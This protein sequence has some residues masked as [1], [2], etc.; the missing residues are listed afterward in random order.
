MENLYFHHYRARIAPKGSQRP[1]KKSLSPSKGSPSVHASATVSTATSAPVDSTHHTDQRQNIRPTDVPKTSTAVTTAGED[2][3]QAMEVDPPADQDGPNPIVV[4]QSTSSVQVTQVTQ[5][6]PNDLASHSINPST[7]QSSAVGYALS[8]TKPP[9]PSIQRSPTHQRRN[10]TAHMPTPQSQSPAPSGAVTPPTPRNK[11]L[12]GKHSLSQPA[13]SSLRSR[14]PTH[15][16]R[17]SNSAPSSLLPGSPT[18]AL[19]YDSFWSS[20]SA[21]TNYRSSLTGTASYPNLHKGGYPFSMGAP[22][23]PFQPLPLQTQPALVRKPSVPASLR[24]SFS[25]STGSG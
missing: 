2:E 23:V 1:D 17:P 8:P 15:P 10:P 6:I 25:G 21:S 13:P 12:T 3:P 4:E 11:P 18:A 19:T 22:S 9:Q 16:I 5:P 7:P 24:Q 14:G 20:H